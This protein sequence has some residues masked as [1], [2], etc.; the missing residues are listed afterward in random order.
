M[1]SVFKY[2]GNEIIDS[3][4][5]V[6]STSLPSTFRDRTEWYPIFYGVSYHGAYL[7]SNSMDEGTAHANGCAPNGF[8]SVTEIKAYFVSGSSDPGGWGN[9]SN[10]MT[11]T[12][13]IA[14]N[15]ELSNTHEKALSITDNDYAFN[16]NKIRFV[17][18][19]NRANDGADFED[20]ISE[21]DVFG[22]KV[23]GP[24]TSAFM[25]ALGVKITWRF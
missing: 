15:G 17:D 9:S 14:A 3:S 6:T 8:T 19:Y 23:V 1:P 4:G 13:N 25:A 12:W 18:L 20:M 11:I 5:V 24:N 7:T 16:P 10:P 21:N 22:I 2:N